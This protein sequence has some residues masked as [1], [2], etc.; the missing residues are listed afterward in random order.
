V[1]ATGTRGRHGENRLLLGSV[2][3]RIVRTSPVPVLTVRQFEPTGNDDDA[4]GGGKPP[5]PN[6]SSGSH[7]FAVS[8]YR[9]LLPRWSRSTYHVR[10][11]HSERR[12]V[13][14]PEIGTAGN[15]LLPADTLEEDLEDQQTAAALEGA[16]VAVIADPDAD[17]L[18]C[19]ALIREAYGDVQ[20]VPGT[21]RGCGRR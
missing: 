16:E 4:A 17:G 6:L 13:A 12:S 15:R 5:T 1:V 7:S 14:R 11:T 9:R 2:A 8:R 21:R 10:R 20:N 19:V 18:A 3:E